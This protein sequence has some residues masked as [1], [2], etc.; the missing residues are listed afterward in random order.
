MAAA[1][2]WGTAGARLP[3][4]GTHLFVLEKYCEYIG[5][6][7]ERFIIPKNALIDDEKVAILM[8]TPTG[9]VVNDVGIRV[10]EEE[11]YV[12]REPKL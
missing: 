7:L 5:W 11:F 10:S 9:T 6:A 1:G 3:D 4:Y 8:I 2:P 12:M